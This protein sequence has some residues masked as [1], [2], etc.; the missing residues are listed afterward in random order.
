M[1]QTPQLNDPAA[2]AVA[3]TPNDATDLANEADYLYVGGAGDLSV[4]LAGNADAD[5]PVLFSNFTGNIFPYR[6][7]RVRATGTTA[8]SIVASW[9]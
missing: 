3:V 7:K 9:S 1:A 6:V 2:K 5:N 4:D 8:T